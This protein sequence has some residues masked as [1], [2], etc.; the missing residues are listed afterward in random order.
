M[1][2]LTASTL[3]ALLHFFTAIEGHWDGKGTVH[4]ID[5]NGVDD[6]TNYRGDLVINHTEE[7]IWSA[8]NQI[9]ND[10][11]ATYAAGNRF[12]VRGNR[13][14]V[15]NNGIVDP[16]NVIEATPLSLT[17]QMTRADVLSGRVFNFTFHDE[18]DSSGRVF[19]AHNTVETNGVV[20]NDE[21]FSAQHW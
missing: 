19:S 3:T 18:L 15:D 17:Y 5:F 6:V 14:F 1:T 10:R 11:G 20:I 8:T 4:Q 16:V 21:V 13:L 12:Q 7:T 2:T 9:S